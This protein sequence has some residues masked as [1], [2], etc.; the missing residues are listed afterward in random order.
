MNAMQDPKLQAIMGQN[1]KAQAMMA[2]MQAHI[3]EHVAFQ[4]RVEIEKMLGVPL[5]P[6]DETLPP[7]VEVELSRAVAMASDKLLQKDQA[8]AQQQQAQQQ[9]QDPVM[10]LQIKAQELKEAEFQH[11]KAMDEANLQIRVAEIQNKAAI[12]NKR[13]DTHAEIAGA[14]I[15]AKKTDTAL[16]IASKE[17]IEGAKIGSKGISQSRNR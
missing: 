6:T 16:G 1:P 17:M 3:S 14:Q 11:K 4:Y 13:I 8:E 15:G 9:A 7:E 10:Q 12:E 2:A 5:P